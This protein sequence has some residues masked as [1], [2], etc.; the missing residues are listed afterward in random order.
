MK[1]KIESK[2]IAALGLCLSLSTSY[3]YATIDTSAHIG[4]FNLVIKNDLNLNT[5]VDG[6][7]IVGGNLNPRKSNNR[8]EFGT[9]ITDPSV[10]SITVL[11]AIDGKVVAQNGT[12]IKYGTLSDTA[13]LTLNGGG[14]ATKLKSGEVDFDAIWDQVVS[15]S[16]ALK[17]L[18]STGEFDTRD[19]N[20]LKF[21]NNN[22]LDLNV[23]NIGTANLTSNG[24]FAFDFSPTAPVIINVGGTGTI[25]LTS[26]ASGNF[27][28]P[29]GA[30]Q[31][32]WNFY[33]ASKINFNNDTWWGSVLAPHAN[34]KVAGGNNLEGG[35]AALSLK[36]DKE[37]HNPLFV[38][39]TPD[40]VTNPVTQ[41]PAPSGLL[42]AA[43]ALIYMSRKRWL[44][45]A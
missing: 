42:I 28:N 3:V 45:P 43:L 44:K 39:I 21:K 35:I 13:N 17:N 12:N 31:V 15:D 14:T 41:V 32:L 36:T 7:A 9:K 30:T 37:V 18:D 25:N 11:G 6:K 29:A 19:N 22:D 40:P 20:Q 26:K 38:G 4:T 34:L 27:A 16:A 5:H 33:E 1:M 8:A 2:L 24:T 23:F 10:D